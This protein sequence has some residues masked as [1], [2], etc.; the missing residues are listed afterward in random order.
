MQQKREPY[1]KP[2]LIRYGRV[3]ELTLTGMPG[4]FMDH[5]MNKGTTKTGF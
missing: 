2:T 1:S 5:N 4:P 3:E